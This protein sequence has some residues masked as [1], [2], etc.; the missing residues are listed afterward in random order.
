MQGPGKHPGRKLAIIDFED[1]DRQKVELPHEE[2]R[3]APRSRC[4]GVSDESVDS[5]VGEDSGGNSDDEQDAYSV[6]TR[7]EMLFDDGV[8]Y[9]G[10]SPTVVAHEICLALLPPHLLYDKSEGLSIL[11]LCPL[12]DATKLRR[13]ST[14]FR[15]QCKVYRCRRPCLARR[16]ASAVICDGR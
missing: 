10:M 13:P 11:C 9:P 1:G 2:V 6:G 7:V 5:N 15:V 3:L 4:T 14:E 16:S 8:W 12:P